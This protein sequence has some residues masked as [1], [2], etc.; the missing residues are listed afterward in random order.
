MDAEAA[1]ALRRLL[2][3]RPVSALGTL[4]RG[5]P[6]VSMVPFVLPRGQDRLVVHVSGLAPHTRDMREH[7]RVG[8]LVMA[9]CATD[10]MPQAL[11]RVALQADAVT[12]PRCSLSLSN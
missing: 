8:L 5:E 6:A 11:P 2:D 7:P 9:E 10:M 1:R 3:P 4:H 12:L